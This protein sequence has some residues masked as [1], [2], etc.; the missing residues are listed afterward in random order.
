MCGIATFGKNQ[1]CTNLEEL[2]PDIDVAVIGNPFD[3]GT[4]FRP[5]ARLAPRAIREASTLLAREDGF[6]DAENNI[7]YLKDAKIVDCGDADML[8][9]DP[10]Y[11]IES[12][13]NDVR[14]IASKGIMPLVLG[15]DHT[16]TIPALQG[17]DQI[18]PFG[19]IHFDAHL[20][21]SEGPGRLKFGQG[22]PMRRASELPYVTEM[23]HLGIRGVGSSRESDFNDARNYGAEIIYAR[24]IREKGVAYALSRIP[25]CDRYYIS[26]DVDGIDPSIIPATGTPSLG[27]LDYY[28][29][30]GILEGVTKM[31]EIIGVDVVELAP[32]YDQSGASSLATAQLIYNLLGFILYNKRNN[33]G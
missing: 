11:C 32:N 19:L 29:I 7:T 13:A 3:Q 5:G 31:G 28:E 14:T 17:L 2:T 1:I 6:Y 21:W 33:K 12:L 15:G 23:A 25:K 27:G 8:H 16:T 20:D 9:A 18:G 26:I 22:N 30:T 24:Q 4:A 10:A